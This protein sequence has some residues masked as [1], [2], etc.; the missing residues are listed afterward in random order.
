M[1]KKIF[2]KTAT[3]SEDVAKAHVGAYAAQSAYF[4]MLCMIPI[5]LLLLTLVQYTPV[6]KAD[7]MT[8]VVQVFPSSVDS[9]IVS[10]VNQVYN[11]SMGIIP[12]TA[13]VALWSAGKGV[14][15]M[16]SGLN[17]IY[18]CHETRNYVFLR[19]RSTIYTVLFIV[20]ILLL[21][22]V[23]VFGNTLN[24]F[25]TGHVKFLKPVADWLIERRA[26][27]TPVVMMGFSLLI[28]KF[29]PNR[30]DTFRRQIP[31]SVFTAVA[32]MVISWVFSVYVDIFRG[33]SDMYGS[34]TTIVLIML[35][36]YCCMYS[37]LLGGELNKL[38]AD[39][40]FS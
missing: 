4:F 35:W 7:V 29:L 23:S 13:L 5:I 18:G 20:V 36:L 19:I 11:Q 33:F 1:L 32:W 12:V 27:I 14:L 2:Q 24:I 22:V 3:V 31:G 40:M 26:V 9:L 28:Y 34:L 21:L 39:K 38:T 15:A 6:T 37:I 25:I 17:C 16:T 8:A 30:K 10:I